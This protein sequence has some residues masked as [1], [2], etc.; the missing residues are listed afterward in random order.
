MK[1]FITITL[2]LLLCMVTFGL[3][4]CGK[5]KDETV[6]TSISS[7]GNGGMVVNRGDYV[8]FVNGYTSFTTFNK[9]N[10]N[11]SFNIGGLYRAKLNSNGELDYDE[12]GSLSSAEKISGNLAGFESTGLYVF[13]NNIYYAT[14]ITEVDKKGNLQNDRL[15]FRRVAIGGGKSE[16][17]YQSGVKADEVDFEFYYAEGRV[18]LLINEN[19]TLKRVNGFGKFAVSHIDSEITSLVMPRDTDDIFESSNY[20]NIF[21]TKT[22]DDSKIEIYNYNIASNKIEYKKVTEYKTCELV[23]YKFGHLYYKAS[24][25]EV[26]NYTYFYRVDGTKNAINSLSAEKLTS[27]SDYTD[28]YLLDNETSGYIAQSENK[29]Y[30][31]NYN[32]GAESTPIPIDNSKLEIIKV[33]NNYIY[34]KSG[35]EIKRI[36]IHN[37]KVNNDATQETVATVEGLQPHGYDIDNN[38]LY[39]Y[40]TAGSNTYLYSIDISNAVEEEKFEKTLLGVYNAGDI[41]EAE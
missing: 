17:I 30:Y 37:L 6:D 14:P 7:V 15:E 35:D 1:K 2:C 22:N 10:L 25:Q 27:D 18:Y 3:A 31:L 12:N 5:K 38:N 24:G 41:P 40:A 11:Q 4:G 21:Y 32:S 19:G 36:N 28:L 33:H 16:V 23:E 20:K 13:G 9:S 8:Y 26:P 34:L 29:T 39:V